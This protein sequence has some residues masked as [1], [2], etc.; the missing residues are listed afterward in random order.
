MNDLS[1]TSSTS[2]ILVTDPDGDH[3]IAKTSK[4]RP[5]DDEVAASWLSNHPNTAYGLGEYRRY[6]EGVWNVLHKDKADFEIL[7]ELKL[8]KSKGLRPT[9]NQLASVNELARIQVSVPN[10]LWDANPDYLPCRNGVL[11]IPTSM[12]LPHSPDYYFTTQLAYDYDPKAE[13]IN[14]FRALRST[15]PEAA[16]FFQE[17]AGYCLTTDTKHEIAIWLYGPPGSGKSTLLS[18]LQAL[19]GTRAGLLGLADIER[20]RFALTNLFGKTLVVSSENPSLFLKATHTLNNLISGEPIEI[21]RKFRDPVLV[22]PRAKLAWA[23]NEL[24]RVGD[25]GNGLFRRV[26]VI[27]FPALPEDKRDLGLKE[28]ISLEGSGILNWALQGLSRLNFRGRFEIPAFVEAETILFQEANDIP[29]LFVAERCKV[30]PELKTQAGLLY[31]AYQAWCYSNG[32][33]VQSSTTIAEDWRRL[34]FKRY[35]SMGLRY[36]R[37]VGLKETLTDRIK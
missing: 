5:T 10:E 14:F 12:L 20:S 7:Q 32:H 35:E 29:A 34:G 22:I 27:R 8:M 24:P 31:S 16:N 25:G 26:K 30:G 18:G 36:W 4:S 23:M 17:F 21:D 1:N 28:A 19:L 13:C 3:K 33:K 11:H 9:K 6:S 37:G 2:P 15:I